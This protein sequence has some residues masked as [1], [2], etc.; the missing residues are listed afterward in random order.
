[1]TSSEEERGFGPVLEAF[2]GVLNS[3]PAEPPGFRR[4]APGMAKRRDVDPPKEIVDELMHQ[5]FSHQALS[6]RCTW[7]NFDASQNGATAQIVGHLEL[8]I[9][10]VIKVD[11]KFKMVEEARG[12]RKLRDREDLPEDFRRSFPNVFALRDKPP[13]YAYL[14]ED[15]KTEDGVIDLADLLFSD[16]GPAETSLAVRIADR[17]MDVL[18]GAYGRSLNERLRPSIM[19]DYV[20]RIR[21]RLMDGAEQN[22]AFVSRPVEVRAHHRTYRPWREYL[23]RLNDARSRIEAIGPPF[24]TF[25]HGDPN[26]ENILVLVKPEEV[27]FSFID[28]KEWG[29]GDY[30]FDIAKLLHYLQVTGPAE[31]LGQ[32]LAATY[33]VRDGVTRLNNSLQVP[34]WVG[35]MSNTIE[36][37]I[38]PFANSK[39]DAAWRL[40]LKLGMASNLLGLPATRWRQERYGSALAFF[41]EG[42][43]YLDDFLTELG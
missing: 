14:M 23:G 16:S 28:I 19:A 43:R 38:A 40:R 32:A 4:A 31:R 22:D 41:A 8:E 42:L 36:G 29:D 35:A 37:R 27:S 18:L 13:V 21:G 5:A 11:D 2:E 26:P 3:L 33:E 15:L 20:D 17:L 10:C 30:L 9:P 34:G 39:G 6:A 25:V 7:R 12:L 24:T 1:M